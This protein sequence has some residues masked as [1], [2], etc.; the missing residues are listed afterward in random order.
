MKSNKNIMKKLSVFFALVI[1]G[2]CASEHISN[3]DSAPEIQLN[4]EST[5]IGKTSD[6]GK[7]EAFLGIPFAQPPVG[8][9]RW[10]PPE[11]LND[12]GHVFH[13][14]HFAPACMQ[15]DRITRWYKNVVKGFG[16]DPEVVITPAVSEDCLYLNIWRPSFE[17]NKD[18]TYPVIVYIHGGSNKAGWSY[19]PNYIGHR[20]AEEKVI[21]ISVAYRLG[22]FGFFSHPAF[23][24]S[25][26]GLMDLVESL[27]WINKNIDAI[28]G[29]ASRITV[30]GESAG[31]GN[32]DYLMAIPSSKGLFSRA[33]HQSSGS[34]IRNQATRED[35]IPL[36]LKLSTELLGA[37]GINV[38]QKLRD[39]E[40]E[41]V[42]AVSEKVYK[43]HYFDNAVDGKSVFETFTDTLKLEKLHPVDLLIGSNEHE[44]LMYLDK[45]ES[46]DNWLKNQ[47]GI[48]NSDNLRKLLNVS[49]N[50]RDQLNVLATASGF[51]CPAINLAKGVAATRDQSWVY[52]FTRQRDGEMAESM[53]AYHGAELPYVFDTH[54][55]WLP[56]SQVDRRLTKTMKNYWTNFAKT[57][58]P[59]GLYLPNWPRFTVNSS[60]ILVMGNDISNALHPSLELCEYL[61]SRFATP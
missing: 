29:D 8:K 9:L 36:G 50:K 41:K 18:K 55:D 47:L 17:E 16:G 31:A 15:A 7:T 56:T 19:E 59:N 21:V 34:A 3:S 42:L 27:R 37:D 46:V 49:S 4:P 22:A 38:T 61:E 54:D 10:A 20:M 32:I 14:H 26:F 52:Y 44:S 5:I 39:A 51:T 45:T 58:N 30:M 57:A 40:A 53:G 33:I 2:S 11:A 6:N 25:N 60:K 1:L 13:A 12:V 43:G 35:H 23:E 24:Y 48:D 28:G